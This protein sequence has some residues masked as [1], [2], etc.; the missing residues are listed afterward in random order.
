MKKKNLVI[1]N[2][3]MN[4]ETILEAKTIFNNSRKNTQNLRN[5]DLVICPPDVFLLTLSKLQRPKNIFFGA[6]DI[7]YANKGAFTGETSASQVLDSGAKFVIIGHSERRALGES[8]EVVARKLQAAFDSGLTPILCI[9]ERERDKEGRH[10]EFVRNQI[11]LALSP[12]RKK[13]LIGLI[14]AYEPVWAIGKSSR[15]AMSPTDIH[16]TVLFIKKTVGELAG[17]DVAQ[18]IRVLYGGSVESENAKSIM[19][20]GNVDGFLVGH[21][22]ISDDFGRILRSI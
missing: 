20:H 16:E 22:S 15:E 5:A 13:N 19:E 17:R 2:W 8:D 6:Q 14:F 3:K 11:K 21:A 9:G 12:L 7:F 10:L 4:P 1:A 18:T